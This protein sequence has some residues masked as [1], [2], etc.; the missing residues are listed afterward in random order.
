[1]K[2]INLT[3]GQVAFV[4]DEDFE[5]I[6]AFKWYAR[7]NP[8][9]QR[10][11]AA[12][13]ATKTELLNGSEEF[14]HMSRFIMDTPKEMF[15]DHEN[16]NTLDNQKHNLRNCTA[17]QNM[18]NKFAYR[19][20]KTGIKGVCPQGKGYRVELKANRKVVFRKYFSNFEDA[21]SA[22]KAAAEKYH[23]EFANTE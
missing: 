23:K 7:W 12:R 6:N 10:F 4:D 9:K 13:R 16:H 14:I 17:S 1:M 18:M 15:C 5:R 21:V 20:S 22:Y 11:Y 8:E 2:T 3:Q 19:N